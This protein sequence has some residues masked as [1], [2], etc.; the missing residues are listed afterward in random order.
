MFGEDEKNERNGADGR[1]DEL[2]ESD[3][4]GADSPIGGDKDGE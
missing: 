4:R 1:V 2:K 3:R